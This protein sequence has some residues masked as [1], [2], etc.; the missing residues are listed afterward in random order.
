MYRRIVKYIFL[1]ASLLTMLGA[2]A[3][4]SSPSGGPRDKTPPVVLNIVPEDGTKNFKGESFSITLDEYVVLDNINEKFMVSPPMVKKP[5]ILIK[6]KSINVNFNE[7]LKDSTTYTFYFL[8]AIKDLN[9]G[10]KIDNFKFVFSTGPVLDSLTVTGNVYNAFDLEVPENTLAIMYQ[11]LADSA[12]IKT[13]P[14]YMSRVDD[15]G[16][17]RFDNVRPGRFRLYALKDVDN[18]KNYNL[19][20]E[21]FA[22]MDSTINITTETNYFPVVIDTTSAADSLKKAPALPV[23]TGEY[24]LFIFT[25][26]K[27]DHYLSSSSRDLPYRLTYTLSLPPDTM[28]FEFAIPGADQN[29]YFTE[30]SKYGDTIQVWL[31]DSS[32]YSQPEIT[33]YV[34]YP[35]TDTLGVI[36]NLEDTIVLRFVEPRT[37]RSAKV[38]KPVYSVTS[39]ISG[40][41]IKPGQTIVFT[42]QTPLRQPDTSRIRLYE[43]LD[44]NRIVL[45]YSFVKDSTNSCKYILDSKFSPGK[46]Y[47]FIA[48]SASFANIFN[49]VTD[50]TGLGFSVKNPDSYGKLTL[51]IKNNDGNLIIQLLDKN[52]KLLRKENISNDGSVVF[53]LLENGFYRVRAIYDLNGDGLW[54][55][56]DFSTREQPEP[57]SYYSTEIEIKTGWELEQDWDV[58]VKN[59]K[60]Q[61]LRAKQAKKK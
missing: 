12:V 20:D 3:K 55:T 47:L 16:Y 52:E 59:L 8:D 41:T 46:K 15:K 58:R 11:D 22:F 29:S 56:G 17:F 21:E 54:S 28:K 39:N 38:K 9:E 36:T 7:E 24:R 14:D 60:N 25:G 2:C 53:P 49:E 23:M 30:R 57:V 6:G 42:S 61:K 50:S 1:I 31:T 26:P 32:L 13:L 27:K 4:I 51:K 37:T 10:N 43:V 40:G 45:P 35:F 34:K 18:S 19:N 48:D 5:D 44:S 33:T